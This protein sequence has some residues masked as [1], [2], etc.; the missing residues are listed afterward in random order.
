MKR[1]FAFAA[2]R[3][4]GGRDA[5]TWEVD[6]VTSDGT[7]YTVT[8]SPGTGTGTGKVVGAHRDAEDDD[9]GVTA[10]SVETAKSGAWTVDART[11]EVAQDLDD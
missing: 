6:V 10:W 11:G 5:G 7:E 2:D 8:V 9:G 4:D 1:T 3:E